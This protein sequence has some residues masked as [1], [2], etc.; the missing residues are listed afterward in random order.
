MIFL[1]ARLRGLPADGAVVH[2]TSGIFVLDTGAGSLAL[3]R[4][5]G[6]FLGI[7]SDTSDSSAISVSDSPLPRLELG[8]LQLDQVSPVLLV[9]A[10]IVKQISDRDAL[11]LMGA[12]VLHGRA[13]VLDFQRN[14]M[15]LV[16]VPSRSGVEA[17]TESER[18][19]S[20]SGTLGAL[21]AG[22]TPVPFRVKGDEKIVVRARVA[23]PT[24]S[25]AS[26]ALTLLLDTGATKTALF[27]SALAERAPHHDAWPALRG[28][29]APTLLGAAEAWLARVPWI[30]VDAA[31]APGRGST[32]HPVTVRATHMDA[33]VLDS[34]L[35]QALS[36]EVGEPVHGLLGYSFL[37]R[38]LVVI[39]LTNRVMWL[40]PRAHTYD[41]RAY[42]YS[43]VGLQL[44][45]RGR[46][47]EV[48]GVASGSPADRAGI[49]RGDELISIDDAAAA[50]LGVIGASQRLEG[51]PGTTVR[52]RTRRNGVER[53]LALVRKRLL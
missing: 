17:E 42:E 24:G 41:E 4:G 8:T 28:L 9:D 7:T 14:E 50:S 37:R 15:T 12:R 32:S 6:H 44:E 10:R 46:A 53:T 48:A 52:L 43:H 29:S 39:D 3:D 2:D 31:P 11:G 51:K 18:I 26:Q 5:L 47:I 16:P 19:R 27:A 23:N 38:F 20:S 25:H 40:A 34:P 22:A 30:A 1:E 13:V 33:A 21:C 49:H 45:R 36:S 35:Q